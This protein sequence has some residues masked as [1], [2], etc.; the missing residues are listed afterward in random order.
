M[1][2]M[3][4]A[5]AHLSGVSTL[6]LLMAALLALVTP[7]AAGA[8]TLNFPAATFELPAGPPLT[9]SQVPF[10]TILDVINP[11]SAGF[12]ASRPL[13]PQTFSTSPFSIE[14]D[15]LTN[16]FSHSEFSITMDPIE[17]D[18]LVFLAIGNTLPYTA[19][20]PAISETIP[21]GTGIYTIR[22]DGRVSAGLLG[23]ARPNRPIVYDS[24]AGEGGTSGG[25][26]AIGWGLQI[27]D[28]AASGS[29]A[30]LGASIRYEGRNNGNTRITGTNPLTQEPI[31]MR[32]ENPIG[33]LSASQ[34]LV[35][36]E[37]GGVVR[38]V[39]AALGVALIHS[40]RA[41]RRAP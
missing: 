23:P 6:T 14:L 26:H 28:F 37:A 34:S 27:T 5:Y 2:L 12:S 9:E 15:E 20:I 33:I 3:H 13:T 41:W 22:A 18:G 8:L 32:L 39:C 36:S 24:P 31:E 29:L 11:T 7:T 25:T 40:R 4:P 30:T 10:F 19:T 38:L 21:A 16:T 35:V 17:T 1:R